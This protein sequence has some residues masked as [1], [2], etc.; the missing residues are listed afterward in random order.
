MI[1]PISYAVLENLDVSNKLYNFKMFFNCSRELR[2]DFHSLLAFQN[3][4]KKRVLISLNNFINK[5]F[6]QVFQGINFVKDVK[7]NNELANQR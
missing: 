4:M 5:D 7:S 3:C 2:D 1:F 6:I